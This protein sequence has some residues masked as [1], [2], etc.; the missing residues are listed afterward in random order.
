VNNS[1]MI[2][3]V[4]RWREL[5]S[6]AKDLDYQ[7]SVLA[8]DIRAEFPKGSD[9]D[10][11]FTK[12]CEVEL[13]LFVA[14]ACEL[15]TRARAIEVCADESTYARVG[16]FKAVR[17]V[18]TLNKREQVAVLEAAKSQHKNVRTIVRERETARAANLPA[19]TN[20]KPVLRFST[21]EDAKAL[22]AFV[23]KHCKD[24]PSHIRAIVGRY[25]ESAKKTAA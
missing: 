11:A 8:R 19:N 23:D 9:G 22:A 10:E 13:G 20:I 3:F 14:A 2:Q 16:G 18:I 21:F 5:E 4:K 7:R 12:W 1:K 24:M 25:V 6:K 17:H 15:L